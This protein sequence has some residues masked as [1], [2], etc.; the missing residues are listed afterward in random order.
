MTLPSLRLLL[1]AVALV[2]FFPPHPAKAEE[3]IHH[4]YSDVQVERDGSLAVTET[5]DLRAERSA[6]NHGI[7][8]DFPT[9]YRGPHG[10]QV[11]VGFTFEGA[12]L[13]GQPVPASVSSMFNGIR[14]K[15][16]DPD[17]YVTV[18][19]HRYVIRYRTTRQLG[20]F[21]G[22]DELYWNVTGTGWMFPI[23]VAEARIRLPLPAKF[24]QRSAYTGAQGAA[25]RAA[26]VVEEKPGEI[27]FR[28]TVG[29]AAYQGLTVAVAFPPGIVQEPGQAMRTAWWLSDYGPIGVGVAALVALIG[30]YFIAWKRAGRNPRAGTIVPIFSPPDDLSPA[31][32]RYVTKMGADNRAFAAALVDMGVRGHIRLSE[33]E[34]GWLSKDKTRLERLAGDNP[35]PPEEEAALR[36][37]AMTGE[38]ILME[39]KNHEKFSSA[40]E[41]LSD[42]LKEKYE[43]TMFLRNWGWAGAGL[44]LFAGAIWLPA[45]AVVAATDNSQLN[46]IGF[47]VG[48]LALAVI[49]IALAAGSRGALKWLLIL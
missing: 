5:I 29:L 19:D 39:Q 18:G 9:R 36:E 48:M 16:G 31:G 34:G 42:A 6:I 46:L 13:D 23:D 25:G 47:A 49:L 11:H 43:G 41:A 2:L 38:T 10:S 7:F 22:Y 35:L 14:V 17:A 1:T 8:R 20:H 21:V 24:G 27:A 3:R 4:F 28:T 15:I 30:Y 45:A 40:K 44:L 26:E 32:M 12:T 33:E 37:L